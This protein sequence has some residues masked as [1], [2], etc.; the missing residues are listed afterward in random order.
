MRL[1]NHCA[2]DEPDCLNCK[3]PDCI[4]TLKDI[5]RQNRIQSEKESA[6]EKK[7][8]N[9]KILE[10]YEQGYDAPTLGKRFNLSKD[11]I[12]SIISSLH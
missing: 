9:E 12:Y 11:H 10:L 5:N 6:L 3:Y 7:Q 4:A 8:R 1:P 2:E